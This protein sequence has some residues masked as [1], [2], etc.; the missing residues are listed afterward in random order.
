MAANRSER[1]WVLYD[2]ANSACSLMVTTAIL[3]LFYK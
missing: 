1:A 3:P 2:V